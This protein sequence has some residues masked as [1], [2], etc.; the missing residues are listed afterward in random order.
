MRHAILAGALLTFA[1]V[2]H[3]RAG[4]ST[5]D[6][7]TA[8]LNDLASDFYL[9]NF[10][11]VAN[12]FIQGPLT[13]G[14]VN[15]YGYCISEAN[16]N[17]STEPP[18]S[19]G[20]PSRGLYG[21]SGVLSTD[22]DFDEMS[23]DFEGNNFLGDPCVVFESGGSPVTAVGG[24][25]WLTDFG[26]NTITSASCPGGSESCDLIITAADGLSTS[27][28]LVEPP[29][30]TFTGFTSDVPI[31][32]IILDST[33]LD[34]WVTV[35]NLYVGTA[36]PDCDFD[37]NVVWDVADI[38]LLVEQIAGDDFDGRFDRNGDL[39]VD[40]D[41]LDACLL[42]AGSINVAPNTSYIYG[43]TDLNGV[44][45]FLDFNRWAANRFTSVA[46]WSKG[47]FN[48]SGVIDFLDFNLWAQNRFTSI[49][50]TAVP[51][52]NGLALLVFSLILCSRQSIR[53]R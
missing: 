51:E 43:D 49:P 38:D 40:R 1:M 15:G 26:F 36:A 23:I 45:D 34:T 24:N 53:A 25:F 4:T 46:A 10:S 35:D 12:G 52:P 37:N 50:I 13:F 48:A 19:F 47:D 44:V 30:T 20:S 8:F 18:G 16:R 14:P 27:T 33:I 42:E 3:G 32:R 41:D 17:T 9:E 31:S 21:N 11:T 6:N 7:Q 29:L 28:T 2:A 22:T 39:A 5:Y